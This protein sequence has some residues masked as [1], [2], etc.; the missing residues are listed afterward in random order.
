MGCVPVCL[1]IGIFQF[2]ECLHFS[3]GYRGRFEATCGNDTHGKRSRLSGTSKPPEGGLLTV[4]GQGR[5]LSL[6]FAWL[7]GC[8]L[9]D[10]K[11]PWQHL[12]YIPDF[13]CRKK[14]K[15]RLLKSDNPISLALLKAGR[16]PFEGEGLE[17]VVS[18]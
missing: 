8:K 16:K 12:T 10:C 6:L 18:E 1:C 15:D 13:E 7:I 14:C 11:H 3:R 9:S 2:S 4:P 5:P 17:P